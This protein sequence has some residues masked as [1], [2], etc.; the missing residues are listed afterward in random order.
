LRAYLDGARRDVTTS[1]SDDYVFVN[2]SGRR[3]TRQSVWQMTRHYAQ[4]A[5]LSNELTPHTLRHSR[6]AHM[7]SAGEDVRRVQAWLGHANI[8]TTQMYRFAIECF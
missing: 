2:P 7:L 5:G 3:I 6:A 1:S 4:A 8:T